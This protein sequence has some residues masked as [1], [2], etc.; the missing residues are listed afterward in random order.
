MFKNNSTD[1]IQA[2]IRLIKQFKVETNDCSKYIVNPT[3]KTELI[4]LNMIRG[5]RKNFNIDYIF[6]N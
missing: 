1:D 4:E 6:I 2:Q 5:I 3:L